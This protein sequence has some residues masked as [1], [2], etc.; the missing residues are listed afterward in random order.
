MMLF[1]GEGVI[2]LWLRF[3]EKS[4]SSLVL[5]LVEFKLGIWGAIFI[6]IGG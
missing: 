3:R 1:F 4:V 6:D 2:E 5:S